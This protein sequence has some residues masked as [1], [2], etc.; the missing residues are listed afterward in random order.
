MKTLKIVKASL[1][2]W[3]VNEVEADIWSNI[4]IIVPLLYQEQWWWWAVLGWAAT[5]HQQQGWSFQ[6]VRAE[7]G[8][9]HTHA[10]T[11]TEQSQQQ[12]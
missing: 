4:I 7:E 11:D 10:D 3:L 6:F 2:F 8:N 9:T 5:Q 12:Y 1:Q